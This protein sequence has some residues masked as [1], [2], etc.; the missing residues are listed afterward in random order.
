VRFSLDLSPAGSASDLDWYWAIV[1]DQNVFWVTPGGASL[2]P[3][4]LGHGPAALVNN[5]TLLLW[6]IGG[7]TISNWFFASD[8]SGI[9]AID[10]MTAV[11]VPS[12]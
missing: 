8:G 5:K 3:A 11:V 4:P 10:H 1:W 2:T 6:T 12:P 9:V 7:T